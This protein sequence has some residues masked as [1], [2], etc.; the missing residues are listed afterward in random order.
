MWR[1]Y[2]SWGNSRAPQRPVSPTAAPLPLA[3]PTVTPNWFADGDFVIEYDSRT[4][5]VAAAI[6][7]LDL[8]KDAYLNAEN[9]AKVRDFAET[10]KLLMGEV[11]TAEQ[12]A[13]S[14]VLRSA[15]LL[16]PKTALE[17]VTSRF[18]KSSKRRSRRR[19]PVVESDIYAL[20]SDED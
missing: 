17:P 12:Q 13:A 1:N 20:S 7:T 18:K 15:G 6:E 5:K 3:P 11:L 14:E 2:N 8:N 9:P 4:M 16:H 10:R 19:A